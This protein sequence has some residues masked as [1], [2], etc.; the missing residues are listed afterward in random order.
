[1]SEVK[2]CSALCRSCSSPS[3]V[4]IEFN[5]SGSGVSNH[6][7]PPQTVHIIPRAMLAQ[8]EAMCVISDG[9]RTGVLTTE[10]I[11]SIYLLT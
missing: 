8:Y 3:N 11:V 5:S 2:P 6:L 1:M 9:A 7:Q 4:R 10:S